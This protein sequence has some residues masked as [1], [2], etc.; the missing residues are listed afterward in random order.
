MKRKNFSPKG[1][2]PGQKPHLIKVIILHC[3]SAISGSW[4]PQGS[5]IKGHDVV[6]VKFQVGK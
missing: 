1:Y 6:S 5:S 4:Y 2:L 3:T